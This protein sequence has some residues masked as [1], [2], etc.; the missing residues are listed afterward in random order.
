M[1]AREVMTNDPI[2]LDSTSPI[3]QALETLH[4]M[5]IRHLPVVNE[6]VLVGLLSDRD[7]RSYTLPDRVAMSNPDQ[8]AKWLSRPVSELMQGDVEAVGPETDLGEVARLMIDYRY[9]AVPVVDQIDGRLVGIISYVDL[10]R[11]V[12]SE[13]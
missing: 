5:D 13:L 11:A 9:G 1:I 8:A 7:L 6:G 4:D 12:E 2:S 10:L 3:R